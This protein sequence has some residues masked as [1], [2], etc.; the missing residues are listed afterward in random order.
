MEGHS[1]TTENT[2]AASSTND[3]NTYTVDSVNHAMYI[4]AN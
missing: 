1:G 3:S 2:N 4:T